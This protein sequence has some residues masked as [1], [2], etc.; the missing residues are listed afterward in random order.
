[1]TKDLEEPVTTVLSQSEVLQ[2]LRDLDKYDFTN[3]ALL[4]GY[5]SNLNYGLDRLRAS[6]TNNSF[7]SID[8]AGLQIHSLYGELVE[9]YEIK[10]N[11]LI[12][13]VWIMYDVNGDGHTGDSIGYNCG[14]TGET[15]FFRDGI[16]SPFVELTELD[17]SDQSSIDSSILNGC[18]FSPLTKYC[19]LRTDNPLTIESGFKFDRNV[20][21]LANN[22][23]TIEPDIVADTTANPEY[24]LIIV[25]HGNITISSSLETAD[26]DPEVDGYDNYDVIEAFLLAEGYIEI[27]KDSTQN[28]PNDRGLFV[29]GGL[30]GFTQEDQTNSSVVNRREIYYANMGRYPVLVVQ[31]NSKYGMLSKQLFG[32]QIDIY[33]SLQGFKP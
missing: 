6:S 14:F 29:E 5:D 32:S 17:I 21:I 24:A 4:G 1:M 12:D 27:E 19:I 15:C 28:P 9:Q 23:V 8:Y 13:P 20:L 3:Q 33:Q 30:V 16:P 7:K 25:A 10:R 31:G 22:S 18:G 11:L 26:M 2:R